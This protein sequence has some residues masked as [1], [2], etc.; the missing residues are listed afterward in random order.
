MTVKIILN[1]IKENAYDPEIQ[2]KMEY[3]GKIE[4]H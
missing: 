4:L 1:P 2:V 3:Y